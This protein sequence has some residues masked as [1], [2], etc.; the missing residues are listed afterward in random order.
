M[1]LALPL[2]SI[3]I[4][5]C[6]SSWIA[7]LKTEFELNM[8][9][10][11]LLETQFESIRMEFESIRMEFESIWIKSGKILK[12]LFFNKARNIKQKYP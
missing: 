10:F 4:K 1:N 12:I 5:N 6:N 7:L 9:L 3:R 11:K 2:E 8:N